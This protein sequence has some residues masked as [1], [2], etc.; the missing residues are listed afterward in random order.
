MKKLNKIF[1]GVMLFTLVFLFSNNVVDA[2]SYTALKSGEKITVILNETTTREFYVVNDSDSNSNTVTAFLEGFVDENTYTYDEAKNLVTTISSSWKNATSVKIPSAL[3]L[4]GYEVTLDDSSSQHNLTEPTW[5]SP[6]TSNWATYWLSDT[7]FT[8][9]QATITGMDT[10]YNSQF[11]IGPEEV[12]EKLYVRL[13]VTVEKEHVVG[14]VTITE[15]ESLWESFV[16]KYKETEL[17]SSAKVDSYSI[18]ATDDS[19]K[20]VI[21]DGLIILQLILLMLTE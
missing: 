13:M 6:N 7:P 4:L 18:S 5:V 2:K 14:G 19:L 10:H 12:T 15:D 20:V 11:H 21:P 8:G 3:E 16:E 9:S 1:M 17:L